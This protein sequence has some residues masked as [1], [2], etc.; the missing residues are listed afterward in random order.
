MGAVH[1][2]NPHTLLEPE[3][4]IKTFI[5]NSAVGI[6]TVCGPEFESRKGQD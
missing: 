5:R 6:A 3:N 2:D 4:P 1:K